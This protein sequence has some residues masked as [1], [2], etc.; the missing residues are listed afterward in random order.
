MLFEGVVT[1]EAVKKLIAFLQLSLDNYPSRSD[2]ERVKQSEQAKEL[3][4]PKKEDV[5]AVQPALPIGDEVTFQPPSQPVS[6]PSYTQT[7]PAIWHA[8]DSDREVTIVGY[9]GEKNGQHYLY[10]NTGAGILA[11]E[12]AFFEDEE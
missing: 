8:A 3:E 5:P 4:Q 10:T 11:S 12:V 9:A 2:L 1:Q 7:G 6:H